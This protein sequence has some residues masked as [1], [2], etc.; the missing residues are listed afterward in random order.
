MAVDYLSSLNSSGS[1]LNITQIVDSLVDAEKTPQENQIQTKIDAKNTAI[2]AIGEVKSALSKLSTALIS[3]TGNTSLS[4]K[5]NSSAITATISNPST[6][7]AINSSI[8]VSTLAKGQT[9]AFENYASSTSLVGA[10]TLLLEKGDWSSGSFITN[11]STASKSLTVSETDTLESLKN[12][13]NALNFGV[14]ASVLS[15]GDDTYTLVLKSQDGKENALRITAS[16]SP[17]GSGLSSIDNTTTNNTKEKLAATDASI[18][19]DG[20]ALTR[21]SN[22][23]T[24]LFTGY[25]VNLSNETSVNGVDTPV[26]LVASVDTE[27][28]ITNL[29]S[30]VSSVNDARELLNEKTFRGSSSKQAGDLSDDPVIKSIEKQINSLTS[31]R[32]IGFG[33]DDIYLSNLGVRTEK[34]GLLSLNQTMLENELKTNPSSLD[35]IFNSMFSSSSSL[36]SVTGGIASAPVAGSY[37]FA[38]TANVSGAFTGLI[39]DDASPEVTSSNNTIQLTVDGTQSSTISIPADHYASEAALATAIQTAINADTTLSSAGKSVTV[40]HSNGAYSI[41][42]GTIGASS[43]ISIDAVGSNL[44]EFLKFVGTT[45]ANNIGTTQTGTASTPLTLDGTSVTAT[46][47]DGLVDNETIASAGNLTLDGAQTSSGSALSLNSFITLT[48]SNDLSSVTFTITGTDINGNAQTETIVGPTANGSIA[49]TK[50]FRDITQISSDDA[51]TD[52]NIGTKSAFVDLDG[53][54]PSITSAG[55]D[56]SSISFTVVGTDMSGNEITE[57]ITGPGANATVLGS[58]TFQTISSIT[59]STNTTGSVTIGSTGAG[60]TTTGVTGTATLDDV[61]MV[62]NASSNQFTITS[63]NAA[64][65]KVQYSGVGADA[66]IYY[67]QSLV[68]KLS[69]YINDVLSLSNGQLSLRETTINKEVSDQSALLVDLNSQMSS[70]RER[71]IKQFTSMEQTVT[72]LKSTGDYLKNLFDTMNKD[73]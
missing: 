64:G 15:T 55:G 31:T 21:P 5:S 32:L 51:V 70:L 33:S 53:K 28:A 73:D 47:T 35:A 57:V 12:K 23:I 20:L 69:S 44:D 11:A 29:Q 17:S 8:S 36:L 39:S 13:I 3:L 37:S 7:V 1:G 24:D 68:E 72:S 42:S 66:T 62:S 71:Y 43:S 41:T 10:G 59:P 45:S 30:F 40:T 27:A 4:V 49:S 25:T 67:G 2:S 60:I 56:E 6:A 19:V 16:E 48:S 50:I 38:M 34:N 9:L 22:T 63:G 54:R 46:D 58:K 61:S 52:I 14:T 65:L 18:T 26:S